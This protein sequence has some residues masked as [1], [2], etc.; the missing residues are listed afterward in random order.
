[1]TTIT[2]NKRTKAGKVLLEMAKILSEREKGVKIS[3]EKDD[4]SPYNPEFVERILRADKR[5][6]YT[7]VKDVK[8]WIESL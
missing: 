8:K 2:V 7:Q 6:E 4:E 5:G 1:M 3:S